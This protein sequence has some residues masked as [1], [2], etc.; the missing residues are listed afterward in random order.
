ME[1]KTFSGLKRIELVRNQ[2]KHSSPK[3]P[4]VPELLKLTPSNTQSRVSGGTAHILPQERA[5]SKFNLQELI[6]YLNGGKDLTKRRKFFESVVSKDPE[7]VNTIYN[8]NRHESLAE[9][10]KE[11]VRIHRPY[12][13]FKPTRW[14]ICIMADK[15]IKNYL[16]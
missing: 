8:L 14:D 4:N 7:L 13:D 10:V 16:R 9:G 1:E 2:L 3:C 15:N 12:K 5:K 11:F 6:D